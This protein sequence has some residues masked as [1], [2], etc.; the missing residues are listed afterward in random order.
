MRCPCVFDCQLGF[1]QLTSLDGLS[2]LPS[3]TALFVHDNRLS[4][5]Q[6]TVRS[7][8]T[9]TPQLQVLDVRFNPFVPLTASAAVAA[10]STA[11]ANANSSTSAA[12]SVAT[13]ERMGWYRGAILSA[14][15]ALNMLDGSAVTPQQRV[16]VVDCAHSFSE[17]YFF[18][19]CSPFVFL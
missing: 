7:L 15:Q 16:C 8:Q 13:G 10:A 12:A 14:L 9:N 6:A 1:N 3:L 4:D 18:S 2:N 19:V 5:V 17:Q 11:N